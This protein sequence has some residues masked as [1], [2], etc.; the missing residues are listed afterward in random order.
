MASLPC[1]LKVCAIFSY[2]GIIMSD[3]I[4]MPKKLQDLRIPQIIF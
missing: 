3:L 1:D 2:P 4:Y